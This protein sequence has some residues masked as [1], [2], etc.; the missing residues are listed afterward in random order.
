MKI[1]KIGGILLLAA[2]TVFFGAHFF[3]GREAE[4][5]D[6][7]VLAE[8]SNSVAEAAFYRE[9]A[10]KL[11]TELSEL[12]QAQYTAQKQCED[13]ITE[14]ESLLETQGRE[15]EGE[16]EKP[17]MPYNYTVSEGQATITGYIGEATSLSIPREIDGAIVV[18]IG[19]SAFRDLSLKEVVIPNTV[20]HIDWFAF[21]GCGM[22]ERIA[23]PSGVMGIEYGAFDG[24][25]RLTVYCE[26]DS[27]A[28]RYARSF[29]MSVVN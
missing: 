27:Y 9:Q 28:D 23:I 25:E 4:T 26:K 10:V 16:G 17:S 12:K 18:A 11:E 1:W 24:C 20:R 3:F 29:G 19:K 15:T 5:S 14:L 7:D 2:S 6:T 22:L 8:L 21:Y 13:R